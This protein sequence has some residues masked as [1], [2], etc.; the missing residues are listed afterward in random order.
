MLLILINKVNPIC[1]LFHE[2]SLSLVSRVEVLE[3]L[4]PAV[5]KA[6]TGVRAH[7]GP[8]SIFLDSLHELKKKIIENTF[9][10]L[11]ILI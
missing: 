7:Q 5:V 3:L 4:T 11:C 1:Y 10:Q 6:G 8:D 2:L 9:Q